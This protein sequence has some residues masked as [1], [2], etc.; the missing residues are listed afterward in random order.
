MQFPEVLYRGG[1]E[2]KIRRYLVERNVV[3]AVIA[4]APDLFFGTNI[5]TCVLILRKN[6]SDSRVLFIDAGLECVREDT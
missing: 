6:K 5:A 3:D 2:E 4:L 1:A